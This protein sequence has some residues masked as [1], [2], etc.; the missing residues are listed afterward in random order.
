LFRATARR[1]GAG[2]IRKRIV[3]TT[4]CHVGI[5]SWARSARWRTSS[6]SGDNGG[7]CIQVGM[8][9]LAI[10]VRDSKNP[11]GPQLAFTAEAWTAFTGQLKANR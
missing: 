8:A 10:A 9:A 7:N 11:G 3:T 4:F 5:G 1:D 6:Y 2:G